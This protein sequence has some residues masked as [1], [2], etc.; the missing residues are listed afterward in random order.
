MPRKR[1]KDQCFFVREHLEGR[2]RNV[3]PRSL[4]LPAP[5]GEA[6]GGRKG[7]LNTAFRGSI[8]DIEARAGSRRLTFANWSSLGGQAGL[9]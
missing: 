9:R 2:T 3:R 5:P 7:A 6:V 1:A 4:L 8:L